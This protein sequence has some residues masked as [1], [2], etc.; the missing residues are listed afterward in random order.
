MQGYFAQITGVE[1]SSLFS[2]N[3]SFV[4]PASVTAIFYFIPNPFPFFAP[5]KWL[6]AY[7]A[8]AL[9]QKFFFIQSKLFIM[10]IGYGFMLFSFLYALK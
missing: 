4:Y 5:G 10:L 8:D 9:R 1:I 7:Y 6:F 2:S 3:L